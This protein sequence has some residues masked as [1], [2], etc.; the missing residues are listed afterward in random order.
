[1]VF[2][3]HQ[4]VGEAADMAGSNPDLWVHQDSAVQTDVIWILL[5]KAFPPGAFDVVFELYAQRTVVP[6]LG[7]TAVDFRA[8]IHKASAF[9]ES[10]NFFHCFFGVVH[11]VFLLADKVKTSSQKNLK[12]SFSKGFLYCLMINN[13]RREVK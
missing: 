1:A 9:A 4:R 7:K 12:T 8:G 6:C 2:A 10:N 5:N 3:V 11:L 13:F